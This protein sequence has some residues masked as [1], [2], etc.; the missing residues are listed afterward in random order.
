[1][2]VER[3][4]VTVTRFEA[5]YR[6][7]CAIA[8]LA[9]AMACELAAVLTR[10]WWAW[11]VFLVLLAMSAQVRYHIRVSVHWHGW[12]GRRNRDKP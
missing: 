3:T 6:E 8:I 11:L 5:R 4:P 9:I 10:T 1:M 7:W 12:S 2:K